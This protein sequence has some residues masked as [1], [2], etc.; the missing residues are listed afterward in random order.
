MQLSCFVSVV[1]GIKHF[2]FTELSCRK[3]KTCQFEIF[4]LLTEAYDSCISE[5]K[6]HTVEL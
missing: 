5:T 2:M 6:N 3:C 1:L 4:R